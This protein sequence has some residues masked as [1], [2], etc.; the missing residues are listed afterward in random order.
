MTE[1]RY[2]VLVD[3]NAHY[4]DE[5]ERYEAGAF[6]TANAALTECRRIVGA[7]LAE[8]YRPGMAAGELI[9]GWRLDG[10][11]P[12]IVPVNGAPAVKFSAW[13]YAKR[14]S[15]TICRGGK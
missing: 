8:L 11:D 15:A 12:F 9:A 13:T 4:M 5:D 7:D 3:D 14:R 6:A 1:A 2:R 10:R